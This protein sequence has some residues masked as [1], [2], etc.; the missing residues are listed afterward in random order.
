[1]LGRPNFI[2]LCSAQKIITFPV[3]SFTIP[4]LKAK[5]PELHNA[6]LFWTPPPI[7]K[8]WGKIFTRS[9]DSNPPENS[10]PLTIK[11]GRISFHS[12]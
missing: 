8:I 1:M 12:K 9:Y 2:D 10:Q 11:Q 7:L 3:I 4:H 6:I 5:F